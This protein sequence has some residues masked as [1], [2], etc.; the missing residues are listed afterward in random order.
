MNNSII[1][2]SFTKSNKKTLIFIPGYSGGLEAPA[3]KELVDYFIERNKSNVFGINLDY[4]HDTPDIFDSSQKNFIT[5]VSEIASNAPDTEVI[6]FAKSLGGALALFN[7]PALPV[8]KMVV[9]GFPVVLGWPQRISLLQSEKQTVPDY[10]SE[11]AEALNAIEVSTLI[12]SGDSDDLTDNRYL[13]KATSA[14]KCLQL[15][16][17]KQANHDL[18]DTETK[19][20]HLEVLLKYIE[21]FVKEAL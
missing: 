3:I 10:R 8:A 2:Y 9:L 11:W 14:N 7:C 15:A 16:V 6:L 21:P 13:S 4:V 12:L 20:L 17:I 18:E 19:K 5:T 1:E